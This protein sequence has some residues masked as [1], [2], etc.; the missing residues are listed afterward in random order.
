MWRLGPEWNDEAA[1]AQRWRAAAP[2]PHLVFDDLVGADDLDAVMA[3]LEEE[4]VE[5]YASDIFA[6]DASAPEPTTAEMREMRAGF[7]EALAPRLARI[8]GRAL[9][10]VDMRSYAYRP[11]HYL[12]PHTDHQDEL[13]RVLAYAYYLPSPAP[14]VGGELELFACRAHDHELVE[15]AP[16]Q[17]F[18]PTANRLVL[19]EVSQRSLHRVHEVLD[20]LR[21]S[22]AGW[23]YP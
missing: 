21:I 9:S 10:R 11:G 7:A 18:A 22:L 1:L 4:P 3:I 12:L 6:F 20:G 2:F 19:F 14:P 15:I 5:H 16:A 13:G 17:R 8:T 23:F